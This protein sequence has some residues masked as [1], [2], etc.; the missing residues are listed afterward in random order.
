[1]KLKAAFRLVEEERLW[2]GSESL[3]AIEMRA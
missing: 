3:Q 1:M 2:R